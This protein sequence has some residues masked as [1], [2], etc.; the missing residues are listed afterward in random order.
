MMRRLHSARVAKSQEANLAQMPHTTTQKLL[1]SGIS[2]KLVIHVGVAIRCM[3]GL[4]S[5]KDSVRWAC[6]TE[7]SKIMKAEK[8]AANVRSVTIENLSET[9][10]AMSTSVTTKRFSSL[11]KNNG[12]FESKPTRN[13][14][15]RMRGPN[16]RSSEKPGRN[17]STNNILRV[18]LWGCFLKANRSLYLRAN[19]S[20]PSRAV[21]PLFA[22]VLGT[23]ENPAFDKPLIGEL[24]EEL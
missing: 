18:F 1:V 24:K 8:N 22:G 5:G 9:S 20:R 16:L 7:T 12:I 6:R 15:A 19:G 14:S 2:V 10:T 4:E 17:Q 11:K 3:K 21:E 13:P 23:E